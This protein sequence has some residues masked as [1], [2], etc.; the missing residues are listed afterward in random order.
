M[1]LEDETFEEPYSDAVGG[2]SAAEIGKTY[3][4]LQRQYGEAAQSNQA[5]FAAAM[6][7]L[8]AERTGPTT[9]EKLYAISSALSRPTRTGKFVETLG[10]VGSVLGA[11]EAEKRKA[12]MERAAMLEK[13]GMGQGAATLENLKTQLA[14]AQQMYRA[15]RTDEATLRKAE[16]PI[17]RGNVKLEDGTNAAVFEDPAT[18]A[19]STAPIDSN[20]FNLNASAIP[21]QAIVDLKMNPALA[22]QFDQEYGP[23]KANLVLRGQ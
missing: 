3:A 14:G 19:L 6:E 10:N 11:Q 4:D 9:A 2:L 17:F 16:R 8:R 12:Q 5:L 22:D 13:Y 23:G 21:P 15:A 1:P 18:G 20:T 7:R